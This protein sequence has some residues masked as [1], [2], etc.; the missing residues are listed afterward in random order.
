[1]SQKNTCEDIQDISETIKV[2]CVNTLSKTV[3]ILNTPLVSA[4]VC[5]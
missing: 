3:N 2:M 4:S 5:E 1:M